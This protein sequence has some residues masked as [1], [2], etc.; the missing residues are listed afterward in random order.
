MSAKYTDSCH[1]LFK[2]LD[3]LPLHSQYILSL[4]TL[5]VKNKDAFKSNSATQSINTR[6]GFDLHPPTHIW[7][8]HKNEYVT[9]E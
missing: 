1:P 7:Q 6:Q 4:S 8:K 5:A 9:P 3:I 2:K